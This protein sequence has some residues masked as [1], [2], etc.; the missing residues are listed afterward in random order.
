MDAET[1]LK[2]Q[3]AC[4]GRNNILWA[5]MDVGVEFD[6]MDGTAPHQLC[7]DG[8]NSDWGVYD[9][10]P[11][12]KQRKWDRKAA[13][14]NKK[15]LNFWVDYFKPIS[16]HL[17]KSADVLFTVLLKIFPKEVVPEPSLEDQV[18]G[19]ALMSQMA[20]LPHYDEKLS[21][22]LLRIFIEPTWYDEDG[23]RL[24]YCADR[25]FAYAAPSP[26]FMKIWTRILVGHPEVAGPW[27]TDKVLASVA[28]IGEMISLHHSPTLGR[29]V[30]DVYLV[31]LASLHIAP[32][33]KGL[34]LS[35]ARY[36]FLGFRMILHK[37]FVVSRDILPARRR[38]ANLGLTNSTL[39]S[40]T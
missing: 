18:Y 7:A 30:W 27:P 21:R 19:N 33:I 37:L 20:Q 2:E 25:L 29:Q 6:E 10:L 24:R 14:R 39:R 16:L 38:A 4:F 34:I 15:S 17:D 31:L 35:Q 13:A 11:I 26:A 36:S 28:C 23:F 3:L 1:T 5:A 12:D 8:N 22:S 9:R 40:S 32:E